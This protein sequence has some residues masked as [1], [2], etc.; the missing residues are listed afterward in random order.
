MTGK[1]KKYEQ[2]ESRSRRESM[3]SSAQIKTYPTAA[4]KNLASPQTTQ[5]EIDLNNNHAY[6]TNN[7]IAEFHTDFIEALTQPLTATKESTAVIAT[8]DSLTF[9]RQKSNRKSEPLHVTN[10]Y[11]VSI[12]LSNFSTFFVGLSYLQ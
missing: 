8:I 7:D 10:K 11:R 2:F 9:N 5:T 3:G 6:D 1:S 4:N 12:M